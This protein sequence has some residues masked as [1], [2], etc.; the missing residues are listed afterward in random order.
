MYA[1][2]IDDSHL[3]TWDVYVEGVG[4]PSAAYSGKSQGPD[5]TIL[6]TDPCAEPIVSMQDCQELLEDATGR[7]S[8]EL[9]RIH[10]A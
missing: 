3:G 8:A 7:Y 1:I 5:F 4:T 9:D 6:I 10:S 2:I